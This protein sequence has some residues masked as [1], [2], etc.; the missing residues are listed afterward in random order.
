[1]H[2]PY[3]PPRSALAR[4]APG[5]P[6]PLLRRWFYRS[7]WLCCGFGAFAALLLAD[8]QNPARFAPTFAA[9]SASML[10]H[11]YCL[12]LAA[13]RLGRRPLLWVGGALLF[14]P[15]G[16]LIAFARMSALLMRES[17]SPLK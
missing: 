13:A 10:L 11:L 16:T 2:N 7:F 4:Q 15:L 12:G 8:R 1:M 14:A 3:A 17:R 9:L 6:S 5:G